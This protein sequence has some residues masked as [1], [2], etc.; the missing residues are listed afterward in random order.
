[1]AEIEV[2]LPASR[3]GP[4]VDDSQDG[5]GC[6]LLAPIGGWIAACAVVDLITPAVMDG[7][8]EPELPMLFA[9]AVGGQLGVLAILAVLGPG[10]WLVRWPIS[11]LVTMGFWCVLLMGMALADLHGPAIHEI[12]AATLMLPFVFLAVQ[13]PLWVL[14]F[15]TGW[16]LVLGRGQ[17]TASPAQR[18]Q[19]G[20]QHML[21][22]TT[23]LAAAMGLAGLGMSVGD[24]LNTRADP[25]AWMALLLACLFF[26]LWSAFST[27]PCLWA[28][29]VARNRAAGVVLI[30]I[31]ALLMSL[32]P[33]AIISALSRFQPITDAVR[34]FVPFHGGLAF[35][36]L[37]SLLA[38]RACGCVL[39][40]PRRMQPP[41]TPSGS[42]PFA[43]SSE[44]GQSLN[45]E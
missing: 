26:V 20:V 11:I 41:A 12:F 39:L 38:A 13:L 2:T 42:S 15:V 3:E 4:M 19:F 5:P 7:S 33:A 28:A 18:R 36:L 45:S 14:R 24:G 37:G 44:G 43:D 21:G 9:G 8:T 29:F 17:D 10:R 35:A 16:C 6:G 40:R 23:L 1:M 25:S 27:V 31:Y 32:L 34:I 22:A 30:A